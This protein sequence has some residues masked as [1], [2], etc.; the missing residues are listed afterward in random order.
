MILCALPTP[1]VFVC[2]CICL[3]VIQTLRR[4][5]VGLNNERFIVRVIVHKYR[6]ENARAVPEKCVMKVDGEAH[7][8]RSGVVLLAG[9]HH[10]L[11]SN[12]FYN[13]GKVKCTRTGDK[14]VQGGCFTYVRKQYADTV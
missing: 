7:E 6:I 4:L 13:T 2:V 5:S 3:C 10:I 11:K 9:L 1:P 14:Y 8:K 12:V